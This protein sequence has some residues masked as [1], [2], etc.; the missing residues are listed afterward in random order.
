MSAVL[1]VA[2]PVF[3]IMITGYGMGRSGVLGPASS[4]ALN[5]F[6]YWAALPALLFL[7]TARAP[8]AE[9]F[10]L[11]FLAAFLGVMLLIHLLG[12]LIGRLLHG[13]SS[14]VACM[15]GLAASFSNTGY[16]G[17]PLFLAAFGPDKLAPAILATVVMGAVMVGIAVVWLELAGKQDVAPARAVADA[18]SALFRNPLIVSSVLGICWSATLGAAAI[19]RPVTIYC[20]LLGAA[21]GPSALFAIGLFLAS[22]PLPRRFGEIG[23][24]VGLKLIVQPALT[25]AAIRWAFPLDPFWTASAVILAALPTGGLTFVVA[26]AYDTHTEK[27]SAAIL[28]STILSLPTLSVLLT[29][30]GAD[31]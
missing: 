5:R 28:V 9:I 26:Q 29:W 23:W 17:I 2:L 14:S 4:D 22:R 30:F 18:A 11:P 27:V 21:A 16:M 24:I 3:G 12:A 7:G 19:P 13:S 6:V 20:E 8:L 25:W 1:N 10:N 31:G 15:Q